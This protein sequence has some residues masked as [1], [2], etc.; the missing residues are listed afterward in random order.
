MPD[1]LYKTIQPALRLASMFFGYS[2]Y[3]YMMILRA[4]EIHAPG[5]N[6]LVRDGLLTNRTILQCLDPTGLPSRED[7]D[8]YVAAIREI[9]E[10]F[11]LYCAED[12]R[13]IIPNN[14]VYAATNNAMA[15]FWI[16]NLF[17]RE[18]FDESAS[19]RFSHGSVQQR[20][21]LLFHFAMTLLHELAHVVLRKRRQN[22]LVRHVRMGSLMDPEPLF[23]PHHVTAELGHAW[24]TW[25]FG[26]T[27]YPT[28]FPVDVR[29]FGLRWSP[30]LWALN[31][32]NV[33]CLDCPQWGVH[34]TCLYDVQFL[35]N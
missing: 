6:V 15:P 4:R 26:G 21:R 14:L 12:Y 19:S 10:Y 28:G 30:W 24:E 20:H 8:A 16:Y 17:N 5:I 25:A 31:S 9:A 27:M 1:D 35:L 22:D 3:F 33:S 34:H 18:Y 29:S 7:E 11:R 23:E 32:H 2:R 13:T